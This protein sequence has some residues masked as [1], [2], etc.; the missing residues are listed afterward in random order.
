MADF[1]PL[2][3]AEI[4]HDTREAVVVTL[5]PRGEDKERF[6]FR[7]GQYLTLRREFAGTELR[8]SYSICS[9]PGEP[10]KVGVKRVAGG[11]F[12]SFAK[13]DLTVGDIVEAMAPQGRFAAPE[14]VGGRHYLGFAAGSGIT[15]VLSIAKAVLGADATAKFTLVYGNRAVSQI[16]FRRELGDLKDRYLGR[17]SLIHVLSGEGGEIPLFCGR[18]DAQ[19][20]R[21]LL[22]AWVRIETVD[23]AFICGP[24]TMMREVSGALEEAGLPKDRIRFELFGAAQPGRLAERPVSSEAQ[25]KAVRAT[26]VIDG[27]PHSFA[28][29]AE[30][31]ILDAARAEGLDAPFSC[32]AGVCST[33][34]G[35]VVEGE[36]EMAQ[37]YALEDY[38][39]KRGLVLTC[40][41]RPVTDAVTIEY[42]GH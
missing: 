4:A 20:T 25:A 6:R 3:V 34:I 18:I 13:S 15:P 17:F 35:R 33:C 36:V 22:A 10:L 5:E 31:T 39:V 9:G 42:G 1:Y 2:R 30:E 16:M 21:D 8:R 7:P 24:E 40:Q 38:E 26:I 12:S 37:N 32:R 23:A 41:A 27:N 11:A 14:E 28:M 29:D 19:K